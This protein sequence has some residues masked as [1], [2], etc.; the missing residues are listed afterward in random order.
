MNLS[1]RYVG[2]GQVKSEGVGNT[3]YNKHEQI[4]NLRN[5]TTAPWRNSEGR[6]WGRD[7]RS[8]CGRRS[9]QGPVM[10]G[11][12]SHI[13][14]ISSYKCFCALKASASCSQGNRDESNP[15]RSPDL[16][17]IHCQRLKYNKLRLA[18]SE[19]F[20]KTLKQNKV[21]ERTASQSHPTVCPVSGKPIQI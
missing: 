12:L 8:A 18:G 14:W 2:I 17:Q 20:F 11:L 4:G 1:H 10:W 19:H 9:G 15:A 3:P 6:S 5:K 7:T 16:W 21:W 13:T